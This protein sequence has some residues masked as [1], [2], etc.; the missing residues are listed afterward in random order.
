MGLAILE[1]EVGV[2]GAL[3]ALGWPEKGAGGKRKASWG[4][5]CTLNHEW[6][7]RLALFL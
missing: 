6:R 2:G 5:G 7:K 3:E 4:G 1:Q